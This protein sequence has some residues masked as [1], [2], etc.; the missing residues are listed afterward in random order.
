MEYLKM[1]DVFHGEAKVE[2]NLLYTLKEEKD[3]YGDIC[4]VN[5]VWA[6][7]NGNTKAAQYAAHAINSHDAL[8]AEVK[9]LNEEL[10]EI[11]ERLGYA[12]ENLSDLLCQIANDD[13]L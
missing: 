9:R 11:Y 10:E 8:V 1:G 13:S 6:G 12:E 5:D 7:F 3:K 4:L 2:D